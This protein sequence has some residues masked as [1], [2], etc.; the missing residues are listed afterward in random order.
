MWGPVIE[1]TNYE[2]EED[3]DISDLISCE[4]NRL[5]IYVTLRLSHQTQ[6]MLYTRRTALNKCILFCASTPLH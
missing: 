1:K 3:Y 4:T 6:L 5:G 2:S